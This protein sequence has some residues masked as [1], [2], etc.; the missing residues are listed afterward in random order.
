MVKCEICG[1]EF[2]SLKGLAIHLKKNHLTTSKLYYDN[3]F[4]KENEE[5]CPITFKEKNF[6]SLSKGYRKFKGCGTN[7]K[8]LENKKTN[9]FCD[10][11][12]I[13]DVRFKFIKLLKKLSIN[14]TNKLQCQICGFEFISKR[15]L[16]NHV[17]KSRDH[18]IEIKEYY[19][20]YL[21]KDNEGTCKICG[22]NTNFI[23]ASDG[24]NI[25]CCKECWY[26]DPDVIK[27]MISTCINNYGD[28]YKK[29]INERRVLTNRR[30]YCKKIKLIE[31]K[32]NLILLSEYYSTRTE[33]SWRCTKCGLELDARVECI[34]SGNCKCP[35]CFPKK[36]GISI[37][38]KEVLSF[39]QSILPTDI[40]IHEN[41]RKI[42]PPQELDIYIPQLNLA[43]EYNGDYWHSEER[44]GKDYHEN[45]T[46]K[47]K[48]LG[49]ELI[50][51][52]E[53]SWVNNN[54]ETKQYISTFF[55]RCL[56]Y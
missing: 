32:Y 17:F 49:I 31:E 48:E 22:K 37:Q 2:V 1:K 14:P 53:S 36:A 25:Y 50:H 29:I 56:V 15:S 33:N 43:I 4:K 24:Y 46:L 10:V 38:E 19:D 9:K 47:C 41:T 27:K 20:R 42:I 12:K 54:E 55:D 26:S 3:Y 40:E 7:S 6:I 18:I 45:K 35:H 23:N 13:R 51:I 16:I 21:K 28:D 52:S 39:I 8:D 30:R 11:K 5:I 34:T 44:I